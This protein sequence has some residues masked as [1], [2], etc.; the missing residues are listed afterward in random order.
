MSR[1]RASIQIFN[2]L[3]SRIGDSESRVLQTVENVKQLEEK[4]NEGIVAIEELSK[5]VQ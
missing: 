1:W 3:D 4:N 2:D 5:E